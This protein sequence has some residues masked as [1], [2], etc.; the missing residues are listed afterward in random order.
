MIAVGIFVFTVLILVY[1][2]S[3]RP[4]WA[5]P[6]PAGLPLVGC[7]PYMDKNDPLKM[8]KHWANQFGKFY[9]VRLGTRNYIVVSEAELIRELFSKPELSA[10]PPMPSF[11]FIAHGDGIA[12]SSGER[13]RSTRRATLHHM[14]NFGM[15]RSRLG[16]VI[17]EQVASFIDHTL[18]PKAGSPVMIDASLNVAVVNIV[19]DLMTS[20]KMTVENHSVLK[21]VEYIEHLFTDKI[22]PMRVCDYLPVIAK[23]IPNFIFDSKQYL[24]CLY[25]ATEFLRS[26]IEEHRKNIKNGVIEEP[27]DYIEALLLEQLEKPELFTDHHI[28]MCL[29]DLFFA[30]NDTTATTLRWAMAFLADNPDVARK[31]QLEIDSRTVN[32]ARQVSLEDRAHMPYTE[33]F[34]LELQRCADIA[35]IGLPHMTTSYIDLAGYH[36]PPGTIVLGL[37]NAVHS[38]GANFEQPYC[39]KPERFL[40]KEEP[41][42]FRADRHVMPFG[43]GRRLCIGEPLARAELFLFVTHI[44]QRFNIC[45]PQGEKP[46]LKATM[47]AG[48]I[49]SPPDFQI[50]PVPRV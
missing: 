22:A 1:F 29:L 7:M 37:L 16:P 4:E 49:S 43:T 5:P 39:F 50:V 32:G 19:W 36:I 12:F 3:K 18:V 33:A 26:A 23:I 2:I 28:T 40:S 31:I 41:P 17:S 35:P 30:G 9:H 15:G 11:D 42:S 47:R 6:G 13:W 48:L 14:R 45:W 10:R 24:Q 27:A 20:E 8:F 46:Q 38:D 44:L 21:R 34:L 25:E